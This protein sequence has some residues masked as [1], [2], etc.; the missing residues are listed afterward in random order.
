[1]AGRPTETALVQRTIAFGDFERAAKAVISGKRSPHTR[2]AYEADLK[3]WTAYCSTQ[4]VDP[5]APRIDDVA[6]FR[7]GLHDYRVDTVRRVMAS[8]SSVYS[9]LLR[10]RAVKRNPFHP[11]VVPWPLANTLPKTR[12]VSDGHATKMIDHAL[13]DKN[14]ARG[15]RDAAVIQ[16]LYDTGLRRVSVAR[17]RRMTYVDGTIHATV[18]GDKEVELELPTSSVAAIDRWLEHCPPNEPYLFPG[19]RG[20][21]SPGTINKLVKRRAGAVGADHV[22]PHSFRAAFVTAGYDAG[23]PEHEIQASVHHSD[24][25]TTRRYDRGVRGRAV[26]TAVEV[27]RKRGGKK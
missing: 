25:K 19:L 18:K 22:H 16:L 17:I 20:P 13:A 27:F 21:I 9:M 11:A 10:G 14:A 8:L 3:R 24:P 4:G 23:L 12:T 15:A 6:D 5:V 1:M 2:S 7:D 26:A